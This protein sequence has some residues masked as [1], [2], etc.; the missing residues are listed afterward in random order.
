MRLAKH[1]SPASQEAPTPQTLLAA[2]ALGKEKCVSD[3]SIMHSLEIKLEMA[4]LLGIE[5]ELTPKQAGL[6]RICL[7][8]A[9]EKLAK[10]DEL[11]GMPDL[12]EALEPRL[13]QTALA[14]LGAQ[15]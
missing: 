5:P 11:E 10:G 4:A 3:L 15:T 12:I 9:W 8:N 14:H 7:E 2:L 6:L 1:L 13:I